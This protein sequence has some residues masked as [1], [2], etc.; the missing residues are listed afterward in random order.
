MKRF[1][2]LATLF[3]AAILVASPALAGVQTTTCTDLGG[4][5]WYYTFFA[6][7][8]N[9][10]ANDLHI[11]LLM[12]EQMQGEQVV[13]CYAPALPGFS[14]SFTAT[15]ASYFF[16]TIG[17][18][19]CVPNLP[20]DINKFGIEILSAD[21]ISLVEEIWT[22]DGVTVAGF[23]SVITCPPVAVEDET[24]GRIKSIYR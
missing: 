22:L 21:G 3:V 9:V 2:K 18:F 24:W 8:P 14:C 15:G 19:D 6:C 5:V 11:N 4:G 1:S 10:D 13:G 23:I 16:P 12:S 7:A 20:G 17:P